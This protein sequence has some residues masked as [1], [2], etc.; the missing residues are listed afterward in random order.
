MFALSSA[1]EE[2]MLS[3]MASFMVDV[4]DKYAIGLLHR[5]C[6][7]SWLKLISSL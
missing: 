1:L 4:V 2:V 6:T 3:I 5:K 7:F